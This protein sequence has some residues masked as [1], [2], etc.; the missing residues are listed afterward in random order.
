M[1][2]RL[3]RIAEALHQLGLHSGLIFEGDVDNAING[4]PAEQG[5]PHGEL[6]F[7]QQRHRDGAVAGGCKIVMEDAAHL[8]QV[9]AMFD[10]N[11]D[12]SAERLFCRRFQPHVCKPD[13]AET[14]L[15]VFPQGQGRIQHAFLDQ[16]RERVVISE[17]QGDIEL[18]NLG[19]SLQIEFVD[20]DDVDLSL[21]HI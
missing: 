9:S 20:G 19:V 6:P 1:P 4:Q 3:H 12:R 16:D 5:N 10:Q 7:D 11:I 18:V 21:I 17:N 15:Q 14:K 2:G 8:V 13:R